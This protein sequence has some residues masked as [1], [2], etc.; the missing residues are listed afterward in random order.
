MG[1][2][3]LNDYGG[4]DPTWLLNGGFTSTQLEN[5][6]QSYITTIM[7]HYQ[8]NYPGVVNRWAIVS[9]AVHLCR[10]FC[11]GL[12][13]DSAGFPAYVSLAYQYARAADPSAQLCYDDWGGEGASST[14]ATAIYNLVAH[15]KSQG[16]IDCVG[17]EG[18][19][20]GDPI[21]AIPT[22]SDIVSNINN[23]GLSDLQCIS[24]R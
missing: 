2:R 10:V 9:E 8:A 17:L 19:W 11:M 6:L 15:L 12:G 22:T 18:Q 13:N 23:L 20:E 1:W 3:P 16:L 24:A 21:S 4:S 14:D 5:I 7:Q